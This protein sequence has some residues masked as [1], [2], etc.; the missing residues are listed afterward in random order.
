MT[1]EKKE[2]LKQLRQRLAN[3]SAQEKE[4]LLNRGLILTIEGR[5]LSPHNTIMVYFQA[6]RCTPT[7]V[8]GFQQWKRAGKIVKKGE[9]GFTIWFPV[10][11]K[12]EDGDTVSAER[13]YTATVFDESQVQDMEP[14][15]VPVPVTA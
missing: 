3:L 12:D 15:S 8:G 7:V 9:H 2:Q 14:A 10:G 4:A 6:T 1:P 5:A 13:F 11:E